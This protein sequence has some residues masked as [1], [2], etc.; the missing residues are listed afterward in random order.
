MTRPTP[1]AL[2]HAE[3]DGLSG[4]VIDKLG[5]VLSVECFSVGMYQRAEAIVELLAPLV[6][7]KHW[8]IRAGPATLP[9]E[10]FE[11]AGHRVAR[12]AQRG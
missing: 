6:G 3:G 7:T 9:Q 12:A 10:G 11:G 8:L 5:D 2:V 1:I 4:L